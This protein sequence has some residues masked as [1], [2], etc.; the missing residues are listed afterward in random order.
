MMRIASRG[1]IG[2]CVQEVLRFSCNTLLTLSPARG[3]SLAGM[4]VGLHGRRGCVVAVLT[5]TRSS[6]NL[7]MSFS[8]VELGHRT[9]E[10][11]K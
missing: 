11:V 3:R 6:R 7:I 5:F 1:I 9:D 2:K 8:H 10:S 4:I